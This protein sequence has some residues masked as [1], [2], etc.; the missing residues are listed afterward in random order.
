MT[1]LRRR[2][3]RTVSP[4]PV[5]N[6]R[7]QARH[8]RRRAKLVKDR[9]ALKRWLTRLKRATSTVAALH[10]RISRLEIQLAATAS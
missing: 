5:P 2:V 10:A 7:Q 4:A 8:E 3:L 9:V 6:G 1:T